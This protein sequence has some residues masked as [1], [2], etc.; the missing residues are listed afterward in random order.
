MIIK[1]EV[2]EFLR[3]HRYTPVLRRVGDGCLFSLPHPTLSHPD[4]TPY[5]AAFS[6]WGGGLGLLCLSSREPEE[7][8]VRMPEY[9]YRVY[10]TLNILEG[11]GAVPVSA[12]TVLYLDREGKRVSGL[13]GV[14]DAPSRVDLEDAL[15]AV[16]T[17]VED[18]HEEAAG[19]LGV[20]E[21]F[22]VCQAFLQKD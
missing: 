5:T 15:W 14:V 6:I 1:E 9:A 16:L 12:A 18:G 20:L 17:E 13:Q 11:C 22:K 2:F 19:R 7:I 8:L 3:E 21:G 10:I 4:S